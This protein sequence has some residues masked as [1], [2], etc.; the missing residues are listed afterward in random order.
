MVT[1]AKRSGHAV[2]ITFEEFLFLTQITVCYYCGGSI[3]W[4]PYGGTAYN[5]DRLNSALGYSFEN[6]AVCCFRCNNLKSNFF[7]SEE[8]K[9]IMKVHEIRTSGSKKDWNELVYYLV[10]WKD[11]MEFLL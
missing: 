1:S 11:E 6:V 8:F 2:D 3:T 10:S 5:L 7:D 9:A 4:E